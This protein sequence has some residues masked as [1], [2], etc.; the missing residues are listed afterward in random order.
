MHGEAF[1][2]KVKASRRGTTLRYRSAFDIIGPAMVGPSSSHTAGPNRVG[3]IVRQL[4]GA[5]PTQVQVSFF[6]SFAETYLGHR[7]DRAVVGG[8]LG[9]RTDD[10][11]NRDALALA[12]AAGMN[13]LIA[14]GTLDGVHPNCMRVEVR[15]SCDPVD[16]LAISIGG[17]RIEIIEIDGYSVRLS[18]EYPTLVLRHIDR[19]GVVQTLGSILARAGVNVSHMEIDRRYRGGEAIAVVELDQTVAPAV[20]DDLRRTLPLLNVKQLEAV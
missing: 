17:G 7:T 13:V 20:L 3:Q 16:A 12:S 14:T 4:A 9:L 2:A 10:P 11:R 5:M 15:G 6:N 1:Y 18:G 19:I 8:L